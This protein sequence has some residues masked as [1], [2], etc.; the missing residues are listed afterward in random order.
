MFICNYIAEHDNFPSQETI[1]QTFGYS[2]KNAATEHLK[3][4]VSKGLITKHC[5]G[6]KRTLAGRKRFVDCQNST[7]VERFIKR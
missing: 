5:G 7:Q 4:L 3:R 1:K 6:F 2:S